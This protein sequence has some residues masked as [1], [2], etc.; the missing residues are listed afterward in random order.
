[1]HWHWLYPSLSIAHERP[2]HPV[3]R[4]QHGGQYLGVNDEPAYLELVGLPDFDPPP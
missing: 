2:Q 4:V 1:V 3:L